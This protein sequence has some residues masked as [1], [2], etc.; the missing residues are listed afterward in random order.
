M[1]ILNSGQYRLS[2]VGLGLLMYGVS[3]GPNQGWH[4]PQVLATIAAGLVL[5][6]AMVAV[7]LR[8]AGPVVDLRLPE[9]TAGVLTS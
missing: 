9:L 7:E 2:G 1:L 8:S 5:L 6:A 3:E 4:Q